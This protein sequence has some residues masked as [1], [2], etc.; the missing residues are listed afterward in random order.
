MD[1]T[2]VSMTRR[3]TQTRPSAAAARSA[4]PRW[5]AATRVTRSS[6]STGRTSSA[7]IEHDRDG[8][9]EVRAR[10]ADRVAQRLDAD[11]DVAHVV[12]GAERPVERG[13]EPDVEH[14][15]EHERA[16]QR[17]HDHGERAAPGGGQQHGS[18]D[19]DEELEREPHERAGR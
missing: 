15:H 19:D 18:D 2:G 14:L 10:G 9:G 16:Q 7:T 8:D 17:A 3:T 1:A 5:P 4:Q 13:E 12:D 11:P 6:A